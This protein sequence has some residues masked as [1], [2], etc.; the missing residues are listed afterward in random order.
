MPTIRKAQT[1]QEKGIA[2]GSSVW[3]ILNA[4]EEVIG[5]ISKARNSKYDIHP[6]KVF[7][8]SFNNQ[9]ATMLATFYSDADKA[10][11]YNGNW[12]SYDERDREMQ[13]T[14]GGGLVAAQLFAAKYL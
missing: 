10:T 2:R 11:I 9:P 1:E 12:A 5:W 4:N 8:R 3:V 14:K 7:R 6:Y 13:N